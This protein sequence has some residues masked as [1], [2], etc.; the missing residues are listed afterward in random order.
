MNGRGQSTEGARY[1]ATTD[2]GYLSLNR[3][4]P[5]PAAVYEDERTWLKQRHGR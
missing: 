3:R 1:R 4:C 2:E 5:G